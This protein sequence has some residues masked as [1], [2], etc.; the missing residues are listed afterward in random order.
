MSG[1]LVEAAYSNK[2]LMTVQLLSS[3]SGKKKRQ[4]DLT[5]SL[6]INYSSYAF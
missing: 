6:Q 5:A 3:F 2:L 1:S 4:L